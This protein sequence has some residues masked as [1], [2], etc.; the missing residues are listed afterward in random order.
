MLFSNDL[1]RWNIRYLGTNT[2]TW[3]RDVLIELPKSPYAATGS[4]VSL[5][6]R[7]LGVAYTN[8]EYVVAFLAEIK[9]YD[10]L[11]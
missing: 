8:S 10:L 3:L 7:S 1:G 9:A 4:R 6:D 5:G 11:Q 2:E